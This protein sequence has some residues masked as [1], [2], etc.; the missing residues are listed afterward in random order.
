MPGLHEHLLARLPPLSRDAPI[1]DVGCGTGAWLQRL[2]DAGYTNLRGIDQDI[3]AFGCK[4]AI[5]AEADLD[6]DGLPFPEQRFAL[7]TAI[8]VIE[9]LENPGRLYRLAQRQLQPGGYLLLTSPNIHSLVARVRHALTGNLGQF[10][11]KGDPTHIMPLLL[12]GVERIAPRYGL[13]IVKLWGYPEAGSIVYRRALWLAARVLG[14]FIPDRVP[15]D[16][17]CILLRRR[18]D[19]TA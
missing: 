2:A 4:G 18:P 6:Q 14:T 3:S 1:L 17:L 8:E 10:D 12:T 5:A 9:H 7:I 11:E 16:A 15:G 13:E 19:G